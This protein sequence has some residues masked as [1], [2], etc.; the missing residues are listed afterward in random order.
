MVVAWR[1]DVRLPCRA[2]GQ[3]PPQRQWMAAGL[4]VDKQQSSPGGGRPPRMQVLQDGT[5]LLTGA[6]RNDEAE[7]T[8]VVWNEHGKD[9]ITYHLL[10]QGR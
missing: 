10:V 3:P 6:Q 5:L 7:Y 4:P 1:R 9:M 2:V 8:C